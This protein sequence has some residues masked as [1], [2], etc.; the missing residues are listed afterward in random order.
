MA[1]SKFTQP[2]CTAQD[3][4]TYK[5]AIDAAIAVLARL[6]AG[7]APHAQDTPNMTVRIDA[8][9]IYDPAAGTFVTFS[10]GDSPAITAPGTNSKIVRIYQTASGTVSKV[11]GTAAASPTPPAYP[12]GSIPICQ[13]LVAAG[14]AEITNAMITDE[15]PLPTGFAPSRNSFLVTQSGTWT[16]PTNAKGLRITAAGPGGGGGGGASAAADANKYGGGGGG[17]GGS[18]AARWFNPE[19]LTITIGTGGAGGANAATAG[20]NGTAGSAGSGPTTVVGATTGLTISCA[21]G[22]GGAAATSAANGAGGA[23]GAAGTGVAGTAGA[24]GV[25]NTNG[26]NGGGIGSGGTGAPIG[27]GA[28]L[29]STRS[30]APGLRGAGGGGGCGFLSGG[31]GGAGGDG[32]VLIEVF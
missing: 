19:S 25:S 9:V 31:A 26:G 30:G 21:A 28:V 29:A 5:A 20:T 17:G 32:F 14:T 3:A 12:G 27:L 22:S 4:A 6:G 16:C 18:V 23:G 11:D 24:A 13:V 7:F 15:R 10:G 2:D 1:A 8:G